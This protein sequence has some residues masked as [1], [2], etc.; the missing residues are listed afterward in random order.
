[1]CFGAVLFGQDTSSQATASCSFDANKQV[2]VNYQRMTVNSKQPVFGR[3]IPYGHV[4]APGGKPLTL[5]LNSPVRVGG[6]EL[7][8][9]A[10]TLFI[11]PSEKAWTLVISRST[12]TSG[13]YDEKQDLAR[14]PMENGELGT[15]ENEFSVYFAHIAPEQCSMRVDLEKYRAWVIFQEK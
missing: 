3:T 1:M 5:F 8:V 11:I 9:G 13:K 12:D 6:G 4:W 15:A 14:I 7:P 10:Y 2:A